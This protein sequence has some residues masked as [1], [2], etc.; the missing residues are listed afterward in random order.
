MIAFGL[1]S[2]GSLGLMFLTPWWGV[3]VAAFLYGFWAFSKQSAGQ[4]WLASASLQATLAM[5]VAAVFHFQGEGLLAG[6]I[7]QMLMI[8]WA[9]ALCVLTGLISGSLA[10][11]AAMTGFNL[12]AAFTP[13]PRPE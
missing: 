2:V 1:F 11:L 4:T 8:K 10:A 6:R 13:M 3:A 12:R 5:I 9:W 7:S